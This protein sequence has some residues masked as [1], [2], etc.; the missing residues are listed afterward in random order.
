D[1]ARASIEFN[2]E[3]SIIQ[4]KL[5]STTLEPTPSPADQKEAILV[6]SHDH[7]PKKHKVLEPDTLLPPE[8]VIPLFCP[9]L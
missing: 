5:S 7:A 3:T 2:P 9:Y 8:S 1:T 6:L 4:S